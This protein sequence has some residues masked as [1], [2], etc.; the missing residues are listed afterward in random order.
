MKHS[1]A[2]DNLANAES[3]ATQPTNYKGLITLAIIGAMIGIGSI[4]M[5]S[6]RNKVDT[7]TVTVSNE[8]AQFNADCKY[9]R[10]ARLAAA[11]R[12]DQMGYVRDE[13]LMKNTIRILCD[14]L[15]EKTF[16]K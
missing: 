10:E 4:S 2:L 9:S 14:S 8:R 7:S 1:T 12:L 13:F 5:F 3:I 16:A 15:T 11:V 6:T